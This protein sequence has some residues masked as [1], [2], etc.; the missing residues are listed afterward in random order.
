[1]TR[2]KP[3]E[4]RPHEVT[5]PVTVPSGQQVSIRASFEVLEPLELNG[6]HASISIGVGACMGMVS[7]PAQDLAAI[8]TAALELLQEN[9]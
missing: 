8:L 6:T 7:G 9:G 2:R 3:T 4:P 5:R 1:M